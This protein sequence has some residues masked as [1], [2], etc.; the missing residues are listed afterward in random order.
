MVLLTEITAQAF[1][2]ANFSAEQHEVFSGVH[3][4]LAA[5]TVQIAVH[6]SSRWEQR[7][8]SMNLYLALQA[9]KSWTWS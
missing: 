2:L 4:P 8:M 9:C 3:A 6:L 7:V 1:G 5:I